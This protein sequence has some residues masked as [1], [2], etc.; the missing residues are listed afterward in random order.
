MSSLCLI[1]CGEA[2]ALYCLLLQ[3]SHP[4]PIA[5]LLYPRA[6]RFDVVSYSAAVG[7]IVAALGLNTI[8]IS[9][10]FYVCGKLNQS[11]GLYD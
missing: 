7:G 8:V 5:S 2:F 6:P 4:Q 3:H 1:T 10:R 9:A 11:L